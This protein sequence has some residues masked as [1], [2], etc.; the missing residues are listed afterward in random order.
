MTN[1]STAFEL[2]KDTYDLDTLKEVRDHGC[3]TGVANEHI[4]YNQTLS[5]F[6]DYEDEIV[7][8]V[9]DH[10]GED[11]LVD[12]F[13]NNNADLTSYKNDIVWTFIE[14]TA[15]QLLDEFETTMIEYEQECDEPIKLYANYSKI[16][17]AALK[18]NGYEVVNS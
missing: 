15:M 2:I 10:L 13:K 18:A 6:E 16:E 4:Y 9:S 7:E 3:V 5:F 12:C 17:A 1:C 14:L 11:Y 8:T